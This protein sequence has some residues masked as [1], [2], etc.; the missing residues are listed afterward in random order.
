MKQKIVVGMSGGVDSSVALMLLKKQGYEPI[1]VSL[2][3]PVWDNVKNKLCEN[4]CCTK[5]SL[6]LA[7]NVC[8]KL[9]VSYYVYDVS[10]DFEKEVIQYFKDELISGKTP[11]PCIYCNRFHKFHHLLKFAE[12]KSINL[13]A[14]GHYAKKEKDNEGNYFLIMPK[15]E[16]KD[17]T[18]G[19]SL[20][21]QKQLQK[22]IFPLGDLMK[23]E[24]FD[25][26]EKEG[27]PIF[28][29]K[30]ESQDFCFVSKKSY[31]CFL[32]E[33]IGIK[34]GKIYD[35]N[36]N[37]LGE[38]PGIHFF[39]I[40]QKK[41]LNLPEAYYVKEKIN[42]DL[43]VSKEKPKGKKV[44]LEKINFIKDIKTDFPMRI[45]AKIR[46]TQNMNAGYLIKD[47]SNY[48]IKFDELQE[49]ITP[50]QFCV[51]YKNNIC[52]GGGKIK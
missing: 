10:D 22:I 7:R 12:K 45:K 16:T 18:Y 50:G 32:E 36:E 26:A 41:G 48:I 34:K 2:K 21:T 14:S 38:H 33:E 20:L 43:I 35:E 27:F 28:L 44:N 6:D 4:M 52:L 51:I 15:D 25:I 11:N 24:V 30:K 31:K 29:K 49:S 1:G 37:I 19:L 9:G 23:E 8:K 39:T 40:G 47:K 13:V 17:Q 5:E 42:N 46:Y 3:L